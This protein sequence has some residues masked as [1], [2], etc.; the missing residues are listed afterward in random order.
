[1]ND[2]LESKI[3]EICLPAE[4]CPNM[5]IS[6]I[7]L[8]ERRPKTGIRTFLYI[9]GAEATLKRKGH[10]LIVVVAHSKH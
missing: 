10:I 1:M 7:S 2:T 5:T 3:R 8:R 6:K 4:D 9:L